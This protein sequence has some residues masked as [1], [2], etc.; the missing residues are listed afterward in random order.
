[1]IW[2]WLRM[3]LENRLNG[4]FYRCPPDGCTDSFPLHQLDPYTPPDHRGR[5]LQAAERNVVFR[6]EDTVNL[7]AARLEQSRHLVLGDILF[8]HS[9]GELPRDDL[10]HRLRLRLFEDALLLEEVVNAGTH[11]LLA[12]RSN[13][14]C[15][16]RA[17]VKSSSGVDR[18]F[19]MNACNAT[20][21]SVKAE[22]HARCPFRRE[23]RPDFP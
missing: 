17:V 20:R 14:F 19:L 21:C 8:L 1:M 13:S 16:F 2:Q 5:P 9:L 11:M 6:I 3:R 4:K 12:H 18:V 23:F 10:F 7:G 15:R 22:Q